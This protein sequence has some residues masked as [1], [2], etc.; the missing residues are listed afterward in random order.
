MFVFIFFLYLTKNSCFSKCEKICDWVNS[1]IYPYADANGTLTTWLRCS[2]N[3][4]SHFAFLPYLAA[5][6]FKG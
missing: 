5:P 4:M 3:P 2:V 6:S 1:L